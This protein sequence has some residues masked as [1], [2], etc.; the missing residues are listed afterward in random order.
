MKFVQLVTCPQPVASRRADQQGHGRR[1]GQYAWR[2]VH[3]E[4]SES[5]NSLHFFHFEIQSQ[6]G[7]KGHL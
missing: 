3:I 1:E 2:I 6:M 4:F 7:G 5:V